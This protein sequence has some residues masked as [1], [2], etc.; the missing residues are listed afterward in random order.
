MARTTMADLITQLRLLIFDTEGGDQIFDDDE[1]QGYLDNHQ[2]EVRYLEMQ[3]ATTIRPGGSIEYFEYHANQPNWEG[4]AIVVNGSWGTLTPSSTDERRGVYSFSSSQE[5]PVYITGYYYDIYSA[6]IDALQGWMARE[7]LNFDFS[8]D[9]ASF[10]RSQKT[11]QIEQ[12][13]RQY[14]TMAQPVMANLIRTDD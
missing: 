4:S 3:P 10:R 8:A 14:Q 1:L 7:K 11:S 12:L 6:A 9:G 2:T 5:P 13:I